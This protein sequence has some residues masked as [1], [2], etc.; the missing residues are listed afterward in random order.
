MEKSSQMMIDTSSKKKKKSELNE[1]QLEA[2]KL[3]QKIINDDEDL[4]DHVSAMQLI[5][6]FK[7][8][9]ASLNKYHVS[10]DELFEKLSI[11]N[12]RIED[13]QFSKV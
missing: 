6:H 5:N 8:Y 10:A 9:E 12:K 4:E 2:D 3:V 11:K 7:L 13:Y 1:A